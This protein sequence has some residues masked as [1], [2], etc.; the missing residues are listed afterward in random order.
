M[1]GLLV[2]LGD[3]HAFVARAGDR[4]L[5]RILPVKFYQFGEG[6]FVTAAAPAYRRLLG[7]QVLRVGA[8]PAGAVLA[9]LEPLISRDNAQQVAWLGPEVLAGSRCCTPWA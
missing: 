8:H 2:P 6:L 5:N 9:A 7:A 3:G 4:E 1:L